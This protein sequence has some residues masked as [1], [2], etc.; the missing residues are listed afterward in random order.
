MRSLEANIVEEYMRNEAA[1]LAQGKAEDFVDGLRQTVERIF[2]GREDK[3]QAMLSMLTMSADSSTVEIQLGDTVCEWVTHVDS[4]PGRRLLYVHGGG[5]LAGS[6]S[7]HRALASRI[8]AQTACVVLSVNY[9]LA[10]EHP[11]PAALDDCLN[12]ANW[13][14]MNSPNGRSEADHLFMVGDSA[15]GGL[16]LA[17]LL[18]RRNALQKQPSAAA[19]LSALTDFTAQ[20]KSMVDNQASDALLS[21]PAI[22]AAGALYSGGLDPNSAEIS[23]LQAK[24]ENLPPLL[25]QVSGSEVLLDDSKTFMREH[26]ASG[27]EGELSVYPGMV[28]VW[29]A[30]APYLPEANSA[31]TELSTF[32]GRY[33]S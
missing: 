28:H 22:L 5:G 21:A 14:A 33:R 13:L 17:T 9:R 24:I 27:G 6:A 10:P 23:P 8:A 11:Y 30:F 25:M 32:I 31:I 12:T 3:P 4:D 7:T 15:G 16:V 26:L 20:S 2:T 29:H 1:K 19:T 18:H